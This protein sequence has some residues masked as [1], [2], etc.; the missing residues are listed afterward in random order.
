VYRAFESL[1]DFEAEIAALRRPAAGAEADAGG[2]PGP[3]TER[4]G[5]PAVTG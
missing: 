1:E 2:R 5:E 3:G 4:A